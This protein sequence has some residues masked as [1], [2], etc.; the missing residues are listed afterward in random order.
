[1]ECMKA[2]YFWNVIYPSGYKR[3]NLSLNQIEKITQRWP[4]AK[5]KTGR[6]I[7]IN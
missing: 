5:V 4:S 6:F 2:F 7:P 1:M 3:Y